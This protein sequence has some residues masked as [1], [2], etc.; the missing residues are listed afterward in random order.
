MTKLIGR[1]TTVPCKKSEVFTTYKDNQP[2]VLIQVFE[3]ER[4]LTKDNNL[5]GKF[6]LMGI[7]PAPRGVP[8]IQ[9]SFNLD[10]N[11]VL[12]VDAKDTKDAS[13]SKRITIENRGGTRLSE[14]ELDEIIK[15]A[16]KYKAE[17][18]EKRKVI[19]AKNDL[20]NYAYQIRNSA[21]DTKLNLKK[22]DKERVLK[23]CEDVIH[24]V[25]ANPNAET[26]EFE[27]KKAELEAVWK[28]I[29]GNV[30]GSSA[31]N[32]EQSPNDNTN[33]SGPKIDEVD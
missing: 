20:E 2:G 28:P 3:G 33:H 5:L 16:E 26:E 30:Y 9:V 18:E 27:A 12:S 11:G 7:P 31:A 23:A 32:H 8:Q 24:W 10:T 6:E 17:D 1:G 4:Q 21:E 15:N 13:R 19:Q 22:E 29:I 14:A 25:D